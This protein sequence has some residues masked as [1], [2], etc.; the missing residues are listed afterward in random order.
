MKKINCYKCIYFYTTWDEKNPRGC[1]YFG[2]KSKMMPS[3]VVF[4]SSNNECKAFKEKR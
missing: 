4:K 1:K 3:L 2:F